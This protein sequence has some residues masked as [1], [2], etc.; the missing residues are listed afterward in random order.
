MSDSEAREL[1][2]RAA[3]GDPDA[4]RRLQ[5]TRCR[6]GQ[7]CAHE[8][9]SALAP[10]SPE[11]QTACIDSLVM[12][13]Q[14]SYI[15]VAYIGVEHNTYEATMSFRVTAHSVEA[16]TAA[17]NWIR[18]TLQPRFREPTPLG[19]ILYGA[20]FTPQHPKEITKHDAG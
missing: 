3:E 20:A 8:L 13:M 9:A 12:E 1:E 15:G 17:L 11:G 5:H 14:Q 7:C 18:H 4:L 10:L 6:T 16:R 19:R 2:R